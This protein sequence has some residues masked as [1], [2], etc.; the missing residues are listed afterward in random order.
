MTFAK[1]TLR[2]PISITALFFSIAALISLPISATENT[3]I[4]IEDLFRDV[5]ASEPI[6]REHMLERKEGIA[7]FGTAL[8]KSAGEYPRH[9][10]RY[11]IIALPREEQF[12]AVYY[13]FTNNKNFYRRLKEGIVFEFRGKLVLATTTNLNKDAFIF[14]IVLD[15]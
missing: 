3:S 2:H 4:S 5:I 8:F 15:E 6:V 10:R 1:I 11:R 12:N 14:D 9:E 13:L 7:I